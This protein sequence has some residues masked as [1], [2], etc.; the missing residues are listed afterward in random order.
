MF[1]RKKKKG[2]L[3]DPQP[4]FSAGQSVAVLTIAIIA[5]SAAG[6]VLNMF[7]NIVYAGIVVEIFFF[8]LPVIVVALVKDYNIYNLVRYKNFFRIDLNLVTIL[9]AV[10]FVFLSVE[11]MDLLLRIFPYSVEMMEWKTELLNPPETPLWLT[12]IAVALIPGICEELLFRSAIQPALIKKLGI[13]PGILLTA[14]IFSLIHFVWPDGIVLFLLGIIFGII[15]FRTGS[16]LYSAVAHVIVNGMAVVS[17]HLSMQ[18][19][20]EFREGGLSAEVVLI[21]LAIL[22]IGFLF[23]FR[24]T[25]RRKVGEPDMYYI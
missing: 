22:I 18:E 13:I 17:S 15:A 7:I 16:F 12:L 3:I 25:P 2:Y 1:R 5:G 20:I 8:A 10:V 23:L 4:L 19:G 6:V 11:L 24:L 14:F 21:L 9:I